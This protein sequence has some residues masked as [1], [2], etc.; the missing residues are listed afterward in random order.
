[1]LGRITIDAVR[2][3]TPSGEFPAK[4]V[5]DEQIA[6]SADIFRDGHD[7]LRARV[8]WRCPGRG[9]WRTAPMRDV[10]NDRWE[11]SV[12]P[13]DVGRHDVVIEAW[14]DR[15]ATWRHDVEIKAAAG[16][17]VEIEL[18]EGAR[19][20]EALAAGVG[21]RQ[22]RRVLD[23]VAGLRRTSCSLHVRL[24]AGL[25]DR[26]AGLVAEVPDADVTERHMPL[27]VDRPRAL[28][29]AWY[30]LFPRSEGGLAGATKRLRAVADMGFDVVYLP[31]IHPIGVTERKGPDNTLGAGPDDPGSPWAI[32]SHEGGHTAIAPELGTLDDFQAFCAEAADVGLEVALDYALQCSPDHPWVHDHPE[33]FWRRPDGSVRYAENP[34]KKYQDIYPINFWPEREADRKALW[35]ACRDVL[36]YWIDHGIR[37]FRV[38]NPHTK[39]MAFW[40]WL[41]EG[42]Q[43]DHP[44][45]IFLSEA[46]TRPKV[47]AKLAEVGFTQSY[48]YFTWRN[49][50][51]ELRDYVNELAYGPAADYMRPS[52]WT[53]TPDIL[54]GPLRH[55]PPAA[56]R[57]R[58]VLAATL[59]PSYGMYSGYELYENEPASDANEEYLHSEKYEIRR[60][61]WGRD[62][63]LAPF[64]TRVN[65]IRR[66]HPAFRWLKNVRFH[67]TSNDRFLVWSKGRLDD[68]DLAL[69][70]VNLDPHGAQESILDLDL[71]AMGL[72]WQGPYS[73]TD[74]LTGET[75]TWDGPGPYVRLDP[76]QGRVAHIL[77]LRA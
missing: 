70:V 16:D 45:V 15:F 77:S 27:W 67:G 69:V 61:D 74:E 1:M 20:L 54:S 65:D 33:W 6:V 50:A 57:L 39:P 63:S 23:A 12:T 51:W 76:W 10:G 58:F 8:R 49:E 9:K 46:F 22:R 26:V 73:A 30:E 17:D 24:N 47:M 5:V 36:R 34:P 75:Y 42:I 38:D 14:R 4:A 7:L 72:P 71:G 68:G 21:A 2:P 40:A 43:R 60:R 25:D 32:G 52:F 62:D 59:V 41:I 66:R 31:P 29:G 53:N 13:A 18:E 48:T 64:I 11:G 56:F 35:A 44:D 3:A 28:Y 19:I 37:I 55:G